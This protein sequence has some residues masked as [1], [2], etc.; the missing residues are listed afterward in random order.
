MVGPAPPCRGRGPRRI[1]G[2]K[3]TRAGW[4]GRWLVIAERAVPRWPGQIGR[5]RVAAIR[6]PDDPVP[7][8]QTTRGASLRP[9]PTTRWAGR[10]ASLGPSA[11]ATGPTATGSASPRAWAERQRTTPSTRPAPGP[12]SRRGAVSTSGAG[13][14]AGVGG[15]NAAHRRARAGVLGRGPECRGEPGDGKPGVQ[16]PGETNHG[17]GPNPAKLLGRCLGISV[18]RRCA[19]RLVRVRRAWSRDSVF[20]L[21]V[22][23]GRG[24]HHKVWVGNGGWRTGR[25]DSW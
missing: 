2:P 16:Q 19:P 15:G 8:W 5:L 11:P 9:T 24:Y 4:A 1:D 13:L 17:A 22:P 3:Y 14:D 6:F 7:R 18:A 12:S 25:V 20:T 21:G 10:R 23:P